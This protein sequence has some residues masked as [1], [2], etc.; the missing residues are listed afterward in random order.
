MATDVILPVLGMAQDSGKIV[1]WLK[2]EGQHVTAG[3]PLV[4]VETD[5]A[6]VDLEAPATGILARVTARAGDEVP[7]AHV[8]A[9]ILTPEEAEAGGGSA[10]RG[11][12]PAAVAAA[13]RP[14]APVQSA[15]PS[16]SAAP[17]AS[18]APAHTPGANGTNGRRLASPKARRI[19]AEREVNLATLRGS[20]PGGVVVAADVLAAEIA[21]TVQVSARNEVSAPAAPVAPAAP[22]A[23]AITAA[24]VAA[25][26]A[27]STIWRLMAERTTQSWTTVPH[28]F[29][30][31]DVVAEGLIAWRDRAQQQASEKLTYTDL[32]VKI[33]AEALRRHP[34]LNAAWHDGA[35]S[36]NDEINVGLAVAVEDGLVVP[37]IHQAD[38]LTLNGVAK[39]RADLVARAQSGKLRP[40]D[41]QDGTF[42]ISNLG[43]YGIDA[44]NAIINAP[45]AAILAVGR[46]A[47]RVVPVNGQPAVRP[48]MTL[49]L[50]CDHRVVDGARGAEFLSTVA[51]LIEDPAGLVQ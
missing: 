29:L 25:E 7:V 48:M 32:L 8:I 38:D 22:T 40:R 50:S 14:A 39:R 19:A 42:T 49:S 9:V 23:P 30:A 46:V 34:R 31:R 17:A 5:K 12:T 2:A 1:E 47:D 4:V 35:I 10:D 16:V 13:A 36:H 6:A 43:M 15:G 24:P 37:V 45:Q 26:S 18:P 21:A 3:E 28:F 51:A 20:G 33:V 27:M 11:P 41:L 44:F